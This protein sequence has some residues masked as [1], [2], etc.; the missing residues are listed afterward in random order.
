ME[1]KHLLPSGSKPLF[2]PNSSF[3]SLPVVW[4]TAFV[5]V[6]ISL[7]FVIFIGCTSDLIYQSGY[8]GVNKFWDI[9]KFPIS[10]F[11][12]LIPALAVL[13]TNH[14]SEQTKEVISLTRSQ[15]NFANYYKHLEEFAKHC[16]N[17][18]TRYKEWGLTI[19]ARL[20]YPKIFTKFSTTNLNMEISDEL[21]D[22][23]GNMIINLGSYG[24]CLKMAHWEESVNHEEQVRSLN[25]INE[26]IYFISDYISIEYPEKAERYLDPQTKNVIS[27]LNQD[28]ME[29]LNFIYNT[30]KVITLILAF[31]P[32]EGGIHKGPENDAR[33]IMRDYFWND[34]ALAELATRG[35]K[36]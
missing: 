30:A 22:Q 12:L 2:D 16:T 20:I 26:Y 36:K 28:E 34:D 8:S 14:R 5:I 19:H 32:R 7:A 35:L 13:A 17:I 33:C 24:H 27:S 29:K 3:F 1:Y 18:E 25:R 10:I 6:I 15:N 23:I 11:A 4:W 31:A 21:P 9:F